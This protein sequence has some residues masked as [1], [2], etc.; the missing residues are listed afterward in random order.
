MA[1]VEGFELAHSDQD[2]NRSVGV[3]GDS[4]DGVGVFG[5]SGSGNINLPLQG[6]AGITG[7]GKQGR[8]GVE[9]QS[10]SG[11]GVRG[12]G[13]AGATG[14]L[15]ATNAGGAG[16]AGVAG[17]GEG[18]ARGVFGHSETGIGVDGES[19]DFIA[20]RGTSDIGIGVWGE[21]VRGSGVVARS[22]P[23]V[24][25]EAQSTTNAGVQGVSSNNASS[26]VHGVN[27]ARGP[28]ITG[29][30][31]SR[32]G[33]LGFSTD[34]HG[35]RGETTRGN[36]VRGISVSG[37]AV[38]G[39]S[40]SGNG[41]AGKSTNGSGVRGASENGLAGDFRGDVRVTG[42]LIKAGGGFTIDH[43]LDPESMYL[44]HSFVESPEM[45]NVYSGTVTTDDEGGA[46]VQLPTY[47]EA[48]NADFRYQLTAIGEFAHAIVSREV[49]DNR[50]AIQTDRP[51]VK[52]CWQV[53]GV[54][55]DA[56]AKANRVVVESKKT[57]DENGRLL[58]PEL[59][60]STAPGIG[61]E[62]E[63]LAA[64]TDFDEEN[65]SA[66]VRLLPESMRKRWQSA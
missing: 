66:L 48:L 62:D 43:P 63:D 5:T 22:G 44:A 14:M 55:R 9:G 40:T 34:S 12:K 6:N 29:L 24:G 53:T 51:N 56:W 36:G 3:W 37:N 45:L 15:G 11:I 18:D 31:T 47:F 26:G 41:V 4:N 30:S 13:G 38:R 65:R 19:S 16:P 58:H 54:R 23:G 17:F 20:V 64:E 61:S 59:C 2:P 57:S 39:I 1:R 8:S 33:V 21:S 49:H 10:D 46:E 50:F 52:V 42:A 32:P 60:N 35:V 27:F 25:V 7:F 28:G